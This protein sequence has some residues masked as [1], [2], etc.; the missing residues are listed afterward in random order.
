MRQPQKVFATLPL[1]VAAVLAFVLMFALSAPLAFAQQ[2]TPAVTGVPNPTV[3]VVHASPDAPAVNVLVDGQPVAENVEFGSATEYLDLTAGDHQVQVVPAD[4]DAAIIDQT[5]TLDGWTSS[6]LA[7][8]GNLADIQLQ[9]QAVDISETDPGQAR[10]RLLNAD[11]QGANLG[12]AIAGSQDP[13]VGGTAFPDAS[14]YAAVNPGTYDMELRNTDS[15]EVVTSSPGFT[16]EAGQVYDL[17][18]L[19]ASEGGQPTL[20][21]LTTP[22]A[23]P[24]SQTLGVGEGPD[25]CLRVIHTAP[26][27]GPVDVTETDPGQ[28]RVRLHN[29]D[30][31]GANLGLAI[32]GS[33]DPL[34]GGTGFQ[35]ASDYAALNPGTYDLEVRNT[36]SGEVVTTSPGFSVEAGQV[37]DL[38]ALGASEGGQPM[39]LALTTPVA[40]PCS[41]T[42]GVGE[43]ADSCL[44]VIHTAPDAGPVDVYIGESPIAEGLEFGDASEFTATP[45][46]EQQLRVVA[47]GQPVDQAIIDMTQGL[48]TGGAGQ[49]LISGTAD[50]TQATI[51]GVDLRALPANQ[52]RVRVVHASPDLDAIDVAVAGDQT[53]FEGIAFRS[54]SGYVVFDAGAVSFQLRENGSDTLLLEAA[55]V[56]LEAGMVY[57]IVAIGRSEDGTL[58]MVVYQANAGTLEG[59]TATPIAATPAAATTGATPAAAATP[60]VAVGST[61]V[62]E[63]AGEATPA[64]TP[65]S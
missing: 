21:A 28:A 44:R 50:D 30:P 31:Q 52:A 40:V 12:L 47:A 51:M 29:A 22:V 63:E 10:L 61:P 26:D 14:D 33:Q 13:L 65:A 16:V 53:P 48:T 7:V 43:A 39:L 38:M 37:Y 35:A 6:I 34:V 3:R 62:T 64:A 18:A 1:S 55:D 45:N 17:M 2:A 23:V 49:V 57:D 36:D 58:Q 20:L 24:C 56:P 5:V 41:Q 60:V 54:A 46:G 27:A 32:A 59:A 19:G 42:L 25:S 4:G 9:Q 11:P 8:T 15:G